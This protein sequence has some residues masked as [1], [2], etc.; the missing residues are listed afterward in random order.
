MRQMLVYTLPGRPEE[1]HMLEQFGEEYRRR[2][3]M[4]LP[5]QHQW[6]Q[7]IYRSQMGP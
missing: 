5:G 1:Q 7:F 4:F 6:R 3:P 2:V